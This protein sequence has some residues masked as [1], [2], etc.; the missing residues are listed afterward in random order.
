MNASIRFSQDAWVG[1]NWTCT[2]GYGEPV[3]DL[4]AHVGGMVIHDPRAA[5][6][7]RGARATWRRT[8]LTSV[9]VPEF[10]GG[11]DLP[12]AIFS[13]AHRVVVP[14]PRWSR[15]PRSGAPGCIDSNGAILS[16]ASNCDFSSTNSTTAFCGGAR[17]SPT[18]RDRL[19]HGASS[20]AGH[21]ALGVPTRQKPRARVGRC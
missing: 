21:A 4:D 18:C 11:G 10:A 3:A 7:P 2:R 12:V 15:V 9:S 5:P 6:R 17:Y 1:G 13:A 19:E 20:Q 16:S 8:A 14:R